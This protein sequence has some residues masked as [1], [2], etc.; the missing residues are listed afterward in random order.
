VR[1]AHRI[2]VLDQGRI[3]ELGTHEEL[4]ARGGLYAH[5]YSMQFRDQELVTPLGK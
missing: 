3:V 1:V 4:M 5:L 2:A